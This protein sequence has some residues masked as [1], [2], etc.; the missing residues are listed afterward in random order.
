MDIPRAGGLTVQIVAELI[1]KQVGLQQIHRHLATRIGA[2]VAAFGI[3]RVG[4]GDD[5]LTLCAV[6]FDQV[7]TFTQAVTTTLSPEFIGVVGYALFTAAVDCHGQHRHTPRRFSLK[8]IRF[9]QHIGDQQLPILRIRAWVDRLRLAV[10]IAAQRLADVVAIHQPA[11]TVFAVTD[12]LHDET[13]LFAALDVHG[14]QQETYFWRHQA[15][16]VILR[17]QHQRIS[18]ALFTCRS[19]QIR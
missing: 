15:F 8:G 7:N 19:R 3:V 17:T 13:P 1:F 2:T 4:F 12:N 10:L 16:T 6:A 5:F 11:F 9:F 14:G 18:A